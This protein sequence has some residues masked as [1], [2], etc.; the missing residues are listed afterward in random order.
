MRIAPCV[1][2]ALLVGCASL[3][4]PGVTGRWG[5]S[6]VSLLLDRTG[7]TLTYPCATGTMDSTWTLGAD[8]ALTATGE[9]YFGGGPV[10]PGGGTPHPATYA[11]HISGNVLTLSVTLTDLKETLG[12]FTL[13]KDGPEVHELCLSP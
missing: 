13:V 8:G 9:H 4:E 11:G 3:M 10:L 1:L 12:P 7:G 5:G 2:A 6:Q